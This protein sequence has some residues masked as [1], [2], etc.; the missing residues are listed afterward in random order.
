MKLQL[1]DSLKK[2]LWTV[3]HSLQEETLFTDG[4]ELCH[5][6]CP[7]IDSNYQT[8]KCFHIRGEVFLFLCISLVQCVEVAL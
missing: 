7:Y 5:R 2:N 4:T 8:V 6:Q 3:L 1:P